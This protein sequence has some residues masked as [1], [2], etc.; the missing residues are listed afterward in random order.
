MLRN[1]YEYE[2]RLAR[3][4]HNI[5][6]RGIAVDVAKLE[7]LRTEVSQEID[8]ELQEIADETGTK[9]VLYKEEAKQGETVL[10]S[11]SQVVKLLES[12]GL[13]VP[14]SRTTGKATTASDALY[15]L[16]AKTGDPILHNILKIREL[17][18]L[19][20]VYIAAPLHNGVLYTS[21]RATG[22][23]TGRR[24]SSESFARLGTNTQNLPK[25]SQWGM[26]YREC[27]VARPGKVFLQVDQKT[28]EDWLVHGMIA[29]AS[30]IETGINEL[31]SGVNRHKKLAA[32]IFGMPENEISKDCIQYYLAKRA[33]YAG[34][35]GIGSNHMAE[36]LASEGQV[37]K[38]SECAVLL[39]KFHEAEPAI[40]GVFQKW[41]IDEI[42]RERRLTTP[43]G[44]TR[45]FFGLRPYAD[46]N[47]IFRKGFAFIPQ[48]TVGDNNGMAIVAIEDAQPIVLAES[49]DSILVEINDSWVEIRNTA[50]LI[51]KAF[52]RR[53]WIP[54]K[55]FG[56]TIPI[57][58][59][60]GYNLGCMT[61]CAFLSDHGLLSTW[62]ALKSQAK[63]L[64]DLC[65]GAE[66]QL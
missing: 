38:P 36:A 41:V 48:S 47:A 34:S 65:S 13:K 46:N 64:P 56:V 23:E 9:A 15:T 21:I 57:E 58:L 12:R 2:I 44:R 51:Q 55:G 30:G 8:K 22:T 20:F 25:H 7:A 4:L 16:L 42:S 43:L 50:K 19:R 53:L 31:L 26:K 18:K 5:E 14:A 52:D 33:R 49:H 61:P 37:V 6:R 11:A 35:Y 39:D 27:L 54:P 29:S 59:E 45:I 24:S 63:L 28:A 62:N 17:G 1:F 40:R 32:F 3:T 66:R 10:N 60:M